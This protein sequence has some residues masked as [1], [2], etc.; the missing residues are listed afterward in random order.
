MEPAYLLF[1]FYK[2]KTFEV[3]V[4]LSFQS[5]ISKDFIL[6]APLILN[7]LFVLSLLN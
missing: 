2:S 5:L 1:A 7:S 6:S 3:F 4:K